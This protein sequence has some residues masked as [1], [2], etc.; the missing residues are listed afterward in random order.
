MLLL[1]CALAGAWPVSPDTQGRVEH[2]AWGC[3][4]HR[5]V[6]VPGTG[7]PGV[8]ALQC[9]RNSQQSVIWPCCGLVPCLAAP[10]G[11]CRCV[12][13]IRTDDGFIKFRV[14]L[15][16]LPM[17]PREVQPLGPAG[18]CCAPHGV[19]HGQG[20]PAIPTASGHFPCRP[21]QGQSLVQVCICFNIYLDFSCWKN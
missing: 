11:C 7:Q 8:P 17:L 10:G 12:L 6:H 14:R 18:P 13:L 5:G 2:R 1:P 16:A 21:E 4:G 9:A 19:F 20:G 3:P 15:S